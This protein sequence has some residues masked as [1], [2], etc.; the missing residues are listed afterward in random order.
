MPSLTERSP[1]AP[2]QPDNLRVSDIGSNWVQLLWDSSASYTAESAHLFHC[3]D[4]L[5]IDSRNAT[6]YVLPFAPA[7]HNVSSFNVSG[8]QGE[9]SY[10]FSVTAV[11]EKCEIFARSQTSNLARSITKP[12][13]IIMATIIARPFLSHNIL[14]DR[15]ET[16]PANG[17]LIAGFEG[18]T[19]LSTLLCS[20]FSHNQQTATVWSVKS[21]TSDELLPV[22][23]NVAKT[24]GPYN[25]MLTI[26]ALTPGLDNTVVYCGT[27]ERLKL[28]HFRLRIY[29]KFHIIMTCYRSVCDVCIHNPLIVGPPKLKDGQALKIREHSENIFI[30]LSDDGHVPFP[31]PQYFALTRKGRHT[32]AQEDSNITFTSS[33]VLFPKLSRSHSGSYSLSITNFMLNSLK[34]VGTFTSTFQV[35]VLCKY[36]SKQALISYCVLLLF[37]RWS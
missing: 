18:A 28:A 14:L 24:A 34:E 33:S 12:K 31:E 17:I 5:V 36:E 26:Q 13:G 22:S 20:V 21:F 30:D 6:G 19:N 7:S 3:Y 37:Y 1:D 32:I 11:S 29:S 9:T 23:P 8:L 10:E 16:S 2:S 27:E 25:S 4:I 15:A 35:D